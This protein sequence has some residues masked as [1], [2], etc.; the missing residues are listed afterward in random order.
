[1]KKDAKKYLHTHKTSNY[2]TTGNLLPI[3]KNILSKR[4]SFLALAKKYKT[5]FYVYD[6]EEKVLSDL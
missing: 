2:F 1:M 5:P 3:V 4:N 6:Q